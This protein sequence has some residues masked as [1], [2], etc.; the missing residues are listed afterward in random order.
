MMNGANEQESIE[1]LQSKIGELQK[2]ID[3]KKSQIKS[4]EI[5]IERLERQLKEKITKRDGKIWNENAGKYFLIWDDK[6]KGTW[7]IAKVIRGGLVKNWSE[8][9]I[10]IVRSVLSCKDDSSPYHKKHVY[11]MQTEF[12]DAPFSYIKELTFEDVLLMVK[13][14]LYTGS[15]FIGKEHALGILQFDEYYNA[16]K[17]INDFVSKTG[18]V[19]FDRDEL[20][21]I[22]VSGYISRMTEAKIIRVEERGGSALYTIN[23]F[24]FLSEWN[25]IF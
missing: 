14:M 7:T 11:T 12:I 8:E 25:K 16:L 13:E 9:K 1:S 20:R 18:R 21:A 19:T 5:S 23:T 10:E 2:E 24:A 3:D 4:G 15:R 6:E 22:G 17:N